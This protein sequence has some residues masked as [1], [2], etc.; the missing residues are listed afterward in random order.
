[1]SLIY[2]FSGFALIL[3]GIII[4]LLIR[5]LNSYKKTKEAAVQLQELKHKINT[6]HLETLQSRPNPHQ[7]SLQILCPL[8]HFPRCPVLKLDVCSI[9]M[10]IIAIH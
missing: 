5:L 2:Y 4:Y 7:I 6:L 3:L 10:L 8:F 9:N 1:M